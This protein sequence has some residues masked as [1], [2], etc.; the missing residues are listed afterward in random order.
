M[1]GLG[2]SV[3]DLCSLKERIKRFLGVFMGVDI[4][5]QLL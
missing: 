3:Y 1:R 4:V 5:S 2:Y